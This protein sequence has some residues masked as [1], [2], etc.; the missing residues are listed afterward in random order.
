LFFEIANEVGNPPVELEIALGAEAG[1]LK[2]SK[3]F[4]LGDRREDGLELFCPC[5]LGVVSLQIVWV[6]ERYALGVL[7]R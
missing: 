5:G 1:V 2:M 7:A 3:S 6:R 4:Q